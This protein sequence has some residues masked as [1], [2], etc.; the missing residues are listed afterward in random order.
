MSPITTSD[1]DHFPGPRVSFWQYI[2][3]GAEDGHS[4]V[5][6]RLVKRRDEDAACAVSHLTSLPPDHPEIRTE[7]CEIS[8][9]FQQEFGD[10][11]CLERF[12]SSNNE[13]RLRTSTGIFLLVWAKLSGTAFICCDGTV[14]FETS[15]LIHRHIEQHPGRHDNS[16]GVECQFWVPGVSTRGVVPIV[17]GR[18]WKSI[19][20]SC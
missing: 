5:P 10:S 17:A 19:C 2:N 12:R 6:R 1:A 20:D 9:S 13:A 8:L 15:S 14:F 3:S 18:E 16:W 7:F 11:S 4:H